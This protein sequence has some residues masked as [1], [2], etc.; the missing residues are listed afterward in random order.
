MMSKKKIH[1]KDLLKVVW[2]MK[3]QE[4]E[5]SWRRKAKMMRD[6]RREEGLEAEDAVM[7]IR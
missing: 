5:Q 4:Q 3:P 1:R 6:E 2:R 7:K